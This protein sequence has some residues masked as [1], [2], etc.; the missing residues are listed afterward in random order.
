MLNKVRHATTTSIT[1]LIVRVLV[2]TVA[3]TAVLLPAPASLAKPEDGP[4]HVQCME[5][6][7][8]D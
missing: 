7:C 5:E 8:A 6:A 4:A 1:R 2:S 3:V